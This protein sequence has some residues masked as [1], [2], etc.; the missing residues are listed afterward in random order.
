MKV[1]R[2]RVKDHFDAA[3]Y[4]KDYDGK[5][6]RMHGHRWEVEVVLEGEQLDGM[7]MLVDFSL[8]K[9]ALTTLLDGLDH[10]VLNEQL[11]EENVTAEFLAW[12]IYDQID[13]SQPSSGERRLSEVSVWESP[14]CCV[15]YYGES[16]G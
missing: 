10:Y 5:C 8:V 7:N 13:I 11:N 15:T 6:C 3:H 12:W 16:N 9:R 4:I 2:L 1:Y 14:G